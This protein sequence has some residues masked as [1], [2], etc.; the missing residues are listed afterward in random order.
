MSHCEGVEVQVD[1][2]GDGRLQVRITCCL[3]QWVR[4]IFNSKQIG[5]AWLLCTSTVV[6][7]Q[8]RLLGEV[9]AEVQA[10]RNVE[11]VSSDGVIFLAH[12]F[13]VKCASLWQEVDTCTEVEVVRNLAEAEADCLVV[14]LIF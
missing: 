4:I 2:V 8:V 9:V 14:I 1:V 3:V 6:D 11:H 10:W 5:H 13:I 12:I 7:T